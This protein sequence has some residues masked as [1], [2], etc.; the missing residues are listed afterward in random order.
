MKPVTGMSLVVFAFLALV[1]GE[2]TLVM[3]QEADPPVNES[4]PDSLE[5][6]MSTMDQARILAAETVQDPQVEVGVGV[7]G[8]PSAADGWA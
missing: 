7:P 2:P 4:V 3:A 8:L 1:A 6:G 5:T